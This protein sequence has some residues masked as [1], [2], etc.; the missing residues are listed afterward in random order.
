MPYHISDS[1]HGG[2]RY[3]IAIVDELDATTAR[4]LGDWLAAAQLNREA[5]FE[6]DVTHAS[7]V[8]ERALARLLTR[9][10]R[11]THERRLA[12]VARDRVESGASRLTLLATFAPLA[13]ALL[14]A[15]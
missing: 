3:E 4:H 14:A 15:A 1:W 7:E 6:L 13:Q 10:E 9:H 5:S 11:L 8:D 12:L 2:Q